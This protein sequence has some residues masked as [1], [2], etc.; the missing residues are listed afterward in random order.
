[1]PEPMEEVEASWGDRMDEE[2]DGPLPPPSEEINGNV[3]KMIEYRYNDEGKQVKVT[4]VFNIE[5]R[6]VSKAVAKR[7]CWKKF[8]SATKDNPNGPDSSTTYVGDDV[9]LSFTTNKEELEEDK[10]D[11]MKKLKGTSIV[12]CRVCKGDHWT[13]KCPYKESLQ[14]LKEIEEKEKI[15]ESGGVDT[16]TMAAEIAAKTGV[17]PTS[18]GGKYVPPSLRGGGDGKERRGETMNSRRQTD[19]AATLRVTNLSE[20]AMESDIQDLFRPFGPIARVYL[21]KDK[22]TNQSKGFAFVSYVKR[23]DAAR[24]VHS[25]NGFGYDHLILS[26]EWAKPST[27]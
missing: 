5:T 12:K 15:A 13:T 11:P 24:A 2:G 27:N 19:E 10:D 6:K 14:P 7:K 18:A 21:A 26:V 20:D 4:R 17:N 3:K 1:M 25:L 9:F 16:S 23:E 22:I 8:G